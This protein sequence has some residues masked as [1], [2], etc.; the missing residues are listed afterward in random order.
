MDIENLKSTYPEMLSNM[1]ARGYSDD[2][3]HRFRKEILRILTES[4]KYGW[5]C[6][7]DIYRQYEKVIQNRNELK[8][9]HALIGAIEKFDLYGEYPNNKWKGFNKKGAYPRLI[10]AF[11]NLVD[12]F[13]KVAKD[14]GKKESTIYMESNN[15]ACFLFAL[16]EMGFLNLDEITESSVISLFVSPEGVR[17]R[18]HTFRKTAT[19]LLKACIP[20]EPTACRKVLSF[21]PKTRSTRKNIQYITADEA[22]RI[23]KALDNASNRLSLCDRAIGKLALYTGLRSSDI[24]TM[25]LTS[26]D[27]ENETINVKQQKSGVRLELP[28]T[29]TVGNAIYDYLIHERPSVDTPAMFLTMNGPIR[30]LSPRNMRYVSE[31]I[32]TEA[33]VRQEAGDRKGFHIFRHYMATTLLGNDVNH[34]VISRTLGHSSPNSTETYLSADFVHLKSCAL[35]ISQFPLSEEVLGFE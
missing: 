24:A 34:A 9:K 25:K 11:K 12:Y 35:S 1:K 22:G 18:G 13:V 33:G 6:Y 7:E 31:K 15:A 30:G 21:L 23:R 32:M 29:V 19:A 20:I 3:T 17:L 10:P 5:K 27:W 14:G 28:L 26:V 16:Q 2:Y 8:K 4:E